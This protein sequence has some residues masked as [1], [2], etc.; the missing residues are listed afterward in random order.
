MARIPH[1]SSRP[2]GTPTE[3]EVRYPPRA[4]AAASSGSRR[5]ASRGDRARHCANA[6]SVAAD[7]VRRAPSARATSRG[8]PGSRRRPTRRHA[9][10]RRSSAT[11]ATRPCACPHARTRRR[12]LQARRW[13]SRSRPSRIRS[14]AI[15]SST[16]SAL[17]R[18]LPALRPRF[19]RAA[20]LQQRI[21]RLAAQHAGPDRGIPRVARQPQP[22]FDVG[23]GE[24]GGR[25]RMFGAGFQPVAQRLRPRQQRRPQPVAASPPC[26]IEPAGEFK[27]GERRPLAV[28]RPGVQRPECLQLMGGQHG[29]RHRVA[30]RPPLRLEPSAGLLSANA[31]KGFG[32][33][34]ILGDGGTGHLDDFPAR[35][36]LGVRLR[37]A[38]GPR[39]PAGWSGASMRTTRSDTPFGSAGSPSRRMA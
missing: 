29:R 39:S 14:G 4:S 11:P 33:H 7:A 8:R 31:V 26:R 20:A 35:D 5:A 36:T 13:A 10:T 30:A 17:V 38:A 16:D 23:A 25:R 9:P 32:H 22:P 27:Q 2:F 28:D 3:T 18:P 19:V 24:F 37:P 15:A 6:G 21:E 12:R 34:R 1:R